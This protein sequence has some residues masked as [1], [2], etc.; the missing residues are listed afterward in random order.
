M[1]YYKR[2]VDLKERKEALEV[3]AE[4]AGIYRT[5]FRDA[6]FEAVRIAMDADAELFSTK[7][8]FGLM[9]DRMAKANTEIDSLK[10]SLAIQE[11]AFGE[12]SRLAKA[13]SEKLARAEA[14]LERTKK[15]AVDTVA[16]LTA[17]L[18]S[19][20][21]D[22]SA[23]RKKMEEAWDQLEKYERKDEVRKA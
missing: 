15:I 14:G 11:A 12:V 1:S 7:Q 10:G 2:M 4:F 22:I 13:I 5:G 17:K 3:A 6:R 19:A 21:A 23:L 18:E 8:A 20:N 16:A 9:M